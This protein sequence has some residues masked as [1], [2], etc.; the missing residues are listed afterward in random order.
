VQPG[1]HLTGRPGQDLGQLA[2]PLGRD[3]QVR[4]V[5]V[6]GPHDVVGHQAGGQPPR[7]RSPHHD[8]P[9]PVGQG[10]PDRPVVAGG[11]QAAPDHDDLPGRQ[12]LD[13]VQHVRADDHGAA[14]PPE[15][16]EQLDERHPLDGVGAVQRLVE[17]EDPRPGDQRGRHFGPLA[18]TLGE[19]ADPPVGDLEQADRGQALVRQRPVPDPVEGRRVAHELAGGQRRRHGLVLGDE[20]D[21]RLHAPLGVRVGPEHPD[22]P[23][24]GPQQ[25]GQ[26]PH[27]GRLA[28]AVRTQQAGHP[29]A[30]RARQ[31]GERH[32][33]AEPHRHG[34][35][36]DGGVG[37][38]RRVEP[39]AG[40][41]R[42]RQVGRPL[43]GQLG[44]RWRPGRLG[45]RERR[46][47]RST[48]R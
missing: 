36:L 28:G 3:D 17:H 4:P 42:G 20:R 21:G 29:R 43:L 14:L 30:E 13:L 8:R 11:R 45:E 7:L 46:R 9:G 23:L 25:P 37:R 5:D 2:G 41:R 39:G 32:L 22:R 38:E 27:E 26:R 15:R 44:K 12:P 19:P 35:N 1:S 18:H 33:L 24:V 48:S 10:V 31:L 40:R 47:H 34:P 6:H 16:L